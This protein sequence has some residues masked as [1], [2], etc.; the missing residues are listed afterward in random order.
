M[1]T[2]GGRRSWG[3]SSCGFQGNFSA[4][5]ALRRRRMNDETDDLI[6][7][8]S[9][10]K[11][12]YEL[13]EEPNRPVS[14]DK[15]VTSEKNADPSLNKNGSFGGP[16]ETK[17]GGVLEN[18]A[19][20]PPPTGTKSTSEAPET[21]D[22]VLKIQPSAPP[23]TGTR[24]TREVP[25]TQDGV[26]KIHPSAP[27]PTG[28]RNTREVPET[29][30]GVLKIHP[31]A[32]P[33]TGTRNT[34]EVPETQTG[35]LVNQA[36]L[37][38]PTGTKNT[39]VAP[40]TG[41]VK[42]PSS[43]PPPKEKRN[44]RNVPK[45]DIVNVIASAMPLAETNNKKEV[46]K[47]NVVKVQTS[48]KPVPEA[49][50]AKPPGKDLP[51]TEEKLHHVD[52]K[53]PKTK[54]TVVAQPKKK[55]PVPLQKRLS[56]PIV[57]PVSDEFPT[58]DLEGQW[59]PPK[60]I[61]V[62]EKPK[63]ASKAKGGAKEEKPTCVGPSGVV[64]KELTPLE[65]KV[66]TTT[67]VASKG[68]AVKKSISDPIVTPVSD[69]F[70]TEDSKEWI[71]PKEVIAREQR[72]FV[73]RD[74]CLDGDQHK[75]DERIISDP[76]VSPCTDE[77]P[78]P[79]DADKEAMQKVD[80]KLTGDV[81][82]TQLVSAPLENFKNGCPKVGGYFDPPTTTPTP[83]RD[84]TT[85]SQLTRSDFQSVS[86]VGPSAAQQIQSKTRPT[87]ASPAQKKKTSKKHR[88]KE[89]GRKDKKKKSMLEAF[90][91]VLRPRTNK[92]AKSKDFPVTN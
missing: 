28:T 48:A 42:I 29:Q 22:G 86:E 64:K 88:G 43:V 4:R 50:N 92:R 69:E 33:P 5:E 85:K 77:Y 57:T 73:R 41:V 74:N 40:E 87:E 59:V 53:L 6:K 75:G 65:Q 34:R 21:Q 12:S 20:P 7:F 89:H 16:T 24:N 62:E 91:K 17:P 10:P 90:T 76:L 9:G 71:A 55:I 13:V 44:T 38:P 84:E 52:K 26:L 61:V 39:R 51:T 27:P 2:R 37:P 36:S 31:S 11:L 3:R 35:V 19:S 1:P 72:F 58:E 23:P 79:T 66:A 47:V 15:A 83:D 54:Q 45:V 46:P 14:S 63:L 30:D 81:K 80:V 8:S 82:P 56:D 60:E 67:N 78:T 70:P 68:V 32:P 49:R 18:Q 25:E